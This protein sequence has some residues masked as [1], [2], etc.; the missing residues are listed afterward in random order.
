MDERS[1]I[2][3]H[4]KNSITDK[5]LAVRLDGLFWSGN[6]VGCSL[7]LS[8]YTSFYLGLELTKTVTCTKTQGKVTLGLGWFQLTNTHHRSAD[9][10]LWLQVIT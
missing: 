4:E 10:H 8:L 1:L 2:F 3:Y 6:K 9:V 7:S 5:I